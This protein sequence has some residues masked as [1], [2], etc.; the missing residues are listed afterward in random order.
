MNFELND[1]EKHTEDAIGELQL[2][3]VLS[4]KPFFFLGQSALSLPLSPHYMYLYVSLSKTIFV[5]LC[6]VCVTRV[7]IVF[8]AGI[9][10]RERE[11]KQ[12]RRAPMGG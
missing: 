10:T 2:L 5:H 4:L 8:D 12:K 9:Q 6:T 7:M 1:S 11:I 3:Q